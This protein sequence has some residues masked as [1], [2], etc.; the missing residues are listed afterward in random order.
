MSMQM[1]F[2]EFLGKSHKMA[3]LDPKA[4]KAIASSC[5]LQTKS[6]S[7]AEAYFSHNPLAVKALLAT[8]V[9]ETPSKFTNKQWMETQRA[10]EVITQVIGYLQKKSDTKADRK[11]LSVQ[12][13]SMLRK[14]RQISPQA[15]LVVDNLLVDC[16][17]N[18]LISLYSQR[19]IT[20]R[21]SLLVMMMLVILVLRELHF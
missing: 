17:I 1:P 13:N 18:P 15:W 8:D 9:V 21:L 4:I 16:K 11:S 19:S 10:D 20:S 12:A 6:L 3:I 2:P 7:V 14:K 5:L